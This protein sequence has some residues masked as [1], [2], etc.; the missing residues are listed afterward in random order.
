MAKPATEAAFSLTRRGEATP[1]AG[2]FSWSGNTMT[3]R[4]ADPLAEG[5]DY[6]A[7]VSTA[8]RDAAGNA[9]GAEKAWD[10]RT[11]VSVTAFPA[12]TVLQ[13]G[14]LRSGGAGQLASDDNSYYNVNSTPNGTRTSSWYGSFAGVSKALRSLKLTYRGKNSATCTQ[15]LA[16]WRWTTSSW[17]TLDSRSVGSTEVQVEGTPTE[18]LANYVNGSAGDGELR[19]RVRCT[20]SSSGFYSSGDLLR[21][22]YKRPQ[23]PCSRPRSFG[24]NAL[25]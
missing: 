12:A 10:F 24:P 4:P 9:L 3:F 22:D 15:T 7:K 20:R 1:V 14:T 11:I 21:L 13:A 6:A 19:A 18:S 2:S 17:V 23:P 5:T 16:L 25:R 8:A